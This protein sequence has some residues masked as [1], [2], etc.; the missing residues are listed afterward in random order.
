MGISNSK[1]EPS[2]GSKAKENARLSDENAKR[3]MESQLDRIHYQISL[4][5]GCGRRRLVDISGNECNSYA[6]DFLKKEGYSVQTSVGGR[7]VSIYW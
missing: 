7:Y 3:M 2:I 6:R 1:G 5:V 4:A